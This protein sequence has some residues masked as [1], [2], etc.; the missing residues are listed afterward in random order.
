M[1]I[2]TIT[3][4]LVSII[5]LNWNKPLD[6][7][8]CIKSI[9]RQTYKNIQTIVVDNGSIDDS[10]EILKKQKNIVLIENKKNR[11][12]TGGHID[13]LRYADGEF[14]LVLNNDA[15]LDKDY[16]MNAVEVISK[17]E[18][19][20]VVGGRSYL[21][22][23]SQ[24]A[25]NT[26]GQFYSFQTI[27]RWSG[28]G[29]FAQ[30]DTGYDHEVNWVSGS[31]MLIRK[32]AIERTGYFYD[33]M[34]AYYEESDLFARLQ[35]AGYVIVY[36]PS[37]KI[38]HKD[39]E[40][41]SSYFQL[42]QLFK[43]RFIFAVRNFDSKELPKFLKSHLHT[44]LRGAFHHLTKRS[45]SEDEQIMNKAL[46]N[47]LTHSIT[48]WPK[49][50]HS[51][52]SLPK[53]DS[54]GFS[55]N[56]KLKIEQTGVS[57]V[58]DLSGNIKQLITLAPFIKN[59]MYKH[60]NSEVIVVCRL[61]DKKTAI[62]LQEELDLSTS[63]LR[64]AFDNNQ[65]ETNPINFGWLSASKE[66]IWFLDTSSLP[67]LES[68]NRAT[69]QLNSEFSLYCEVA[70][71]KP[72]NHNK[73]SVY[74]NYCMSRSLLSL[75]GGFDSPT[76]AQSLKN[77]HYF[78][79]TFKHATIHMY[80][81]SDLQTQSNALQ[82]TDKLRLKV[83]QTI[84]NYSS[85]QK[86]STAL[87][88]IL[89]KNY[90]LYQ[91][92]NLSAWLFINDISSRHKLARLR[93]TILFSM[94]LN[95][96]AL[97]TELKHISNE[98]VKSKHSG[99]NAASRVAEIKDK[100]LKMIKADEWKS[101]PIFIICRDRV[102]P[103]KQLI[104]WLES[105]GMSNIILIDNDS[106]YPQL[107][108]FYEETKYQ[109]IKT[110]KNVGHTVVWK[111]GIIKTLIPS[112]FYIVTDPDVIPDKKC[113]NDAIQHFYKLH[114]KYERYQKIGF[115]LQID[116]LPNHYNLKTQVIEWESQFWKNEL[117]PGVYEA[118]VDTTFALYKPYVY[119][120]ILHPSIRS[121]KPYTAMHLP[122]YVDSSQIDEEEAFYRM[123]AS[124]DITSWN[125]D[126]I[127]DRYKEE[128]ARK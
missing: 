52:Y 59:V 87:A 21:W 90:R 71:T 66:Y 15:I 85:E 49:W 43:N 95:R 56:D 117:E 3:S 121:G 72:E 75:Y 57:F 48:T 8:A 78:A 125:T 37:L 45:H 123:H 42:N 4:P 50:I 119:D 6:T 111:E 22:Q 20:A 31:S 65:I 30:T 108:K 44:S 28:E 128:L 73:D 17:D 38:W 61:E 14:I 2:P 96:K 63:N 68:I 46:T 33:P 70:A 18:M 67:S 118:G 113:P 76:T 55:F 36:S 5:I 40:S 51:R 39:G 98:V 84:N 122:W 27:N 110:G 88:K 94:Q 103:L 120:Y 80:Q 29:I 53:K 13:G 106:I 25:Y 91:L 102:T 41:S 101:T 79:N 54:N 26:N 60:Y 62:A 74:S 34:F 69:L 126:E 64:F 104:K 124:Q 112:D 23:N 114:T 24:Q 11:G 9:K 107:L 109:V 32:T 82:P 10:V 99:F 12:F 58:C 47:A 105:I 116:D 7:V 35:S 89:E 92:H 81:Y 86:K 100:S 1:K 83:R 77:I 115:G 127:L 19:I 16:V 97:A 93:N